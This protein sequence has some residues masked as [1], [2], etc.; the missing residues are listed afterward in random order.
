[1]PLIEPMEY[2]EERLISELIIVIDTSGSCA[3]SLTQRF[4]ECTRDILASLG[5][6]TRRFRMHILQCD[7]RVQRDDRIE[8]MDEFRRYIRDL[9]VVGGGGTDFRPAFAR[10]DAYVA[11]GE[12]AHLKGILFF[13]D[14]RGIYPSAK[15]DYDVT[16]VFFKYRYDAI[17]AP[18]W[19]RT[20]V[21]DAPPPK[22][23]EESS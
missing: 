1:M 8:S 11:S 6:F 20:V 22:G 9:S 14:G 7:A 10:A 17:D 21:L 13:S 16:F 3:R 23:E 19:V 2:R 12:L 18:S 15:P 5:L 4:L